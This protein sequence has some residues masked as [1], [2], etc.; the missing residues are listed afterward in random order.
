MNK[1]TEWMKK[2]M[3]GKGYPDEYIKEICELEEKYDQEC[4]EIADQCAAEGYP[5]NGDNYELRCA[6]L[7][8]WYD[9]QIEAV[10]SEYG[11]AGV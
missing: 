2:C 11:I 10:D 8:K 6:D 3:S 9:E 1:K 7:R 4:Q 5:E